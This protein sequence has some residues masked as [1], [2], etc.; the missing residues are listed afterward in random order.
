M[1]QQFKDNLL[2]IQQA[3]KDGRIEWK[4]HKLERMMERRISR[5][6]IKQAIIN[7]QIVEA[8]PDDSPVPSLLICTL[9]PQPLHV[10][11]AYSEQD[12]MCHIITVYYP[13][14]EH[15]EADF[16]TRKKV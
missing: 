2:L 14:L 3:V 11:L 6:A 1:G 5:W 9:K 4:K 13:D 12:N 7:G 8:Y 15:F 10:V 16:I